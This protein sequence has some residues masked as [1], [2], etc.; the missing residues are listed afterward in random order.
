[1]QPQKH[2]TQRCMF[3]RGTVRKLGEGTWAAPSRCRRPGRLR[4]R[5]ASCEV[6][7]GPQASPQE[8][9]D[10]T[11]YVTVGTRN[12]KRNRILL[13]PSSVSNGTRSSVLM[14]HARRFTNPVNG[15]RAPRAH[16]AAPLSGSGTA[17]ARGSGDHVPRRRRVGAWGGEPLR[18]WLGQSRRP[19]NHGTDGAL[20]FCSGLWLQRTFLRLQLRPS[21]QS[22][23]PPLRGAPLPV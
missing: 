16:P 10:V 3:G 5:C 17:V 8:Q 22:Q 15:A 6:S 12:P 21:P 20:V 9:A 7:A 11:A 23:S 4:S 18:D 13:S 2:V 19:A 1:M 14:S